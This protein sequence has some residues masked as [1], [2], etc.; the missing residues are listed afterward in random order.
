MIA[1]RQTPNAHSTGGALSRLVAQ[2][3]MQRDR[4]EWDAKFDD[5][6]DTAYCLDAPDNIP[7]GATANGKYNVIAPT[8]IRRE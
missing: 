2:F 7:S 1:T 8:T 4:R 6:T 3:T 5:Y